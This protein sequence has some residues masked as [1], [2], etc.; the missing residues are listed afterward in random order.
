MDKNTQAVEPLD[1]GEFHLVLWQYG[2]MSGFYRDLWSAIAQ[3]DTD[4]MTRLSLGFPLDVGA[5]MRF[6]NE[7][8][9]WDSVKRRALDAGVI[10]TSIPG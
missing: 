6:A 9:Y 10:P 4:N 2:V 3:A 1:D 8:G 7:P 5:Y